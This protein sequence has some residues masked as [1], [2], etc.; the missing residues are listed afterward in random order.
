[1]EAVGQALITEATPLS[2]TE[3]FLRFSNSSLLLLALLLAAWLLLS[4]VPVWL[5][6]MR[7]G[8]A[9][10]FLFTFFFLFNYL[11][12]VL[13]ILF[14][15]TDR[16]ALYWGTIMRY[17]GLFAFLAAGTLSLVIAKLS[18]KKRPVFSPRYFLAVNMF[19][20]F[21]AV[22]FNNG[23][24]YHGGFVD[25][26]SW[27]VA[28]LLMV[29]VTVLFIRLSKSTK[30][31]VITL[32]L[33]LGVIHGSAV[34]AR[35]SQSETLPEV[36]ATKSGSVQ[37]AKRIILITVD[38]LRKD[39]LGIY[40]QG[41]T[42]T[43]HM[44][45]LG[46]DSLVFTQ[47]YAS[48][49]W[50]YPSVASFLTGLSPRVHGLVDGTTALSPKIP[51]LAE[52][53]QQAGYHS[54]G[55][56]SNSLLLPRSGLNRGFNEYYF[57]PQQT[58]EAST[59]A[60]GISHNLLR[61]GG[62]TRV[63]ATS[64]TD[65][66]IDWLQQ[67]EDDNFF[68]W[69]HYF[70]PHIPYAPPEE[71]LPEDPELKALG[72]RFADTR[73]ARAGSFARGSREREWIKALYQGDVSYTDAQIGRLMGALKILN[74]YDDSLI[75]LTSDHGEEFWEHGHFE[76]GHC[77]YNE[78][79]Q[80]PFIWKEAGN[81]PKAKKHAPLTTEAI[82][83]TLLELCALEVPSYLAHNSLLPRIRGEEEDCVIAPVFI[84]STLFH[85][86]L[87]AVVFDDHKYL[88][89]L[90]SPREELYNLVD[91]PQEYEPVPVRDSLTAARGR[92]LL[93]E[94]RD[95]D[96]A[97][98]TRFGLDQD[99]EELLDLEDIRSLQALGYL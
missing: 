31:Q 65:L 56:G 63:D 50:T 97:L 16:Y 81:T 27:A 99:E 10:L 32:L 25:A 19:L 98:R 53:M 21:L 8:I 4:I 61:L 67:H 78:V 92:T 49:P 86:P 45:A 89:S 74:L 54:C 13:D 40:N 59:F 73:I 14:T 28:L 62:H 36:I 24:Y 12:I 44:D 94:S 22:L 42:E 55:I 20:F 30:A 34:Y 70:D 80:V 52:A 84:G 39:A 2:L 37:P 7:G 35:L 47:A 26:S 96:A 91:D 6:G 66:A 33:L 17:I 83:P 9:L 51:T 64:L 82:M 77:L 88:H 68:L 5:G 57:F 11:T 93:Q 76:H 48:S 58:F 72:N 23:H 1:M 87:E 18:R 85:D 38:T 75:I 29:L 90:N 41:K 15:V 69:L 3:F 60:T 46:R 43:P 79:V 95:K 71:W